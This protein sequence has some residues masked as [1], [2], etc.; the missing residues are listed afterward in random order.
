[1]VSIFN[2]ISVIT[3]QLE[4]VTLIV[5][6]HGHIRFLVP[7]T[8][9]IFFLGMYHEP[10]CRRDS[11]THSVL[12]VGFGYEGRESEGKKYWLIKNRYK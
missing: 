10:N 9:L 12:L 1:M 8:P 7:F 3:V 5:V 6:D 2:G 11:P 4:Y